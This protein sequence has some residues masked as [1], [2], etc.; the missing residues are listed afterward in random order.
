MSSEVH[1]IFSLDAELDILRPQ[2]LVSGAAY[3]NR[4]RKDFAARDIEPSLSRLYGQITG[5]ANNDAETMRVL[6][7]VQDLHAVDIL[8]SPVVEQSIQRIP[9]PYD[10]DI[11]WR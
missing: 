9:I 8:H 10:V 2:R 1:V 5:P 4:R 3:P 11:D 7:L 6:G